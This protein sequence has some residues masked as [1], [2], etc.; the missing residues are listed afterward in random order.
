[1]LDGT[2]A[3]PP[4]AAAPF[5]AVDRHAADES[6]L[7][8][9]IAV[10]G[11][12]ST[13]HRLDE[14][15]EVVAEETL[16]V[17]GASIVSISRWEREIDLL[18]AVINVGDLRWRWERY[19]AEEVYRLDEYPI[20]ARLLREG[21]PYVIERDDPA[22][23]AS[24]RRLLEGLG[25]AV[26]IGVPIVVDGRIWGLLD[27]FSD[28]GAPPPNVRSVPF[29]E[30]IASQIGAA[31]GRAE[32]F[33]HV[34]ALA[35]TDPL[36]GLANRRALDERIAA[37]VARSAALAIAFCDLDGLKD[38]NDAAGHDAGDAALRRAADALATAA[39]RH[40]GAFV[41]R[42][43]GDEFCVVVE[44]GD[45]DSAAAAPGGTAR[46]PRRARSP[47]RCWT[48][49]TGRPRTNGSTGSRRRCTV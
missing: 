17:T 43:G 46:P 41:C 25:A 40:A 23:P 4:P 30:A 33:A 18:R 45:E 9:L 26:C 7:R 24:E 20:C 28:D 44:G 8:A 32:L 42:I 21:A 16:R 15:L 6:E 3:P 38:I 11:A 2:P 36:T 22:M 49:S 14:V 13:A 10:S 19:P 39:G 27:A 29:L 37:A 48:R 12:V 5:P 34:S 47:R 31:I 1:M 35:Y